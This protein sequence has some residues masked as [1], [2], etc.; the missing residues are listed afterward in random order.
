MWGGWSGVLE[1]DSHIIG[2]Q[3]LEVA[4]VV[5]FEE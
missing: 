3:G 2:V 5:F 1:S 4:A